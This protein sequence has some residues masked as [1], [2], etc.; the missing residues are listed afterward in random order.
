VGGITVEVFESGEVYSM[1]MNV[2]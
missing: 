1:S 2:R